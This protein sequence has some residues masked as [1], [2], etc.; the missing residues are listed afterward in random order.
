M[1][2]MTHSEIFTQPAYAVQRISQ[3]WV[4]KAAVSGAN[5]DPFGGP[6]WRAAILPGFFMLPD[7][8]QVAFEIMAAALEEFWWTFKW[9]SRS[10][11]NHQRKGF[12]MISWF[13]QQQRVIF[14]SMYPLDPS[15]NLT[16]KVIC[17]LKTMV[18][19]T[20]VMTFPWCFLL[21]QTNPLIFPLWC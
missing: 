9:T 20:K 3:P 19:F 18:I 10:I 12:Q 11:R 14:Q 15:G 21:L 5:L 7:S 2:E 16:L 4:G 6:H 1:N 8:L 13:H 17:P